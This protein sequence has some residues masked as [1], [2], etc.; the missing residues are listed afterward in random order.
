MSTVRL[1]SANDVELFLKILA[2]ESVKEAVSSVSNT[3]PMQSRISDMLKADKSVYSVD[4]QNKNPPESESDPS[5]ISKEDNGDDSSPDESD[6][7]SDIDV[8][9]DSVADAIKILRSGRSVDDSQ[10]SA[11]MRSYFDRLD[12]Q[13]RQVLLI[14]LRSFAGILTGSVTGADAQDPS[15][16]P[17]SIKMSPGS[18]EDKEPA[19]QRARTVPTDDEEDEE[20]AEGTEDTSPPIRVGEQRVNEIREK[21]KGL[22]SL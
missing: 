10:I 20:E 8:S 16:P 12:D 4:E 9:L 6:D 2:E 17:S 5:I 14:F 18:G 19:Q 1:E 7:K 22:M 3:D 21:V 15:D 11:Q 13:E